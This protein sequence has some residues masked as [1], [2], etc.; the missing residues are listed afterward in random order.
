[1]KS[2]LAPF[3]GQIKAKGHSTQYRMHKY[4]ARRKGASVC[5]A[6][7]VR[8]D[9]A[10]KFV[11]DRLKEVILIP[12]HIKTDCGRNESTNRNESKTMEV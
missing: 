6:N 4:Y 9:E 10:E 5:H 8:A 11:L 12:E 2:E 7:S 1:M 3:E